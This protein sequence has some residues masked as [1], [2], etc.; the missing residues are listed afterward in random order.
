MRAWLADCHH[1]QGVCAGPEVL[2]SHASSVSGQVRGADSGPGVRKC[3]TS[4]EGDTL[5]HGL[6]V[7]GHRA[8]ARG[9]AG[10]T[11]RRRCRCRQEAERAAPGDT[12]SRRAE[13]RARRVARG[14]RLGKDSGEDSRNQKPEDRALGQVRHGRLRMCPRCARNG[15][16]TGGHRADRDSGNTEHAPTARHRS[17]RARTRN[18]LRGGRHRSCGMKPFCIMKGEWRSPGQKAGEGSPST[19]GVPLAIFAEGSSG[20][21]CDRRPPMAHGQAG[22]DKC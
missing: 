11:R 9:G 1:C 19:A 13:I 14:S 18:E 16:R 4:E 6:R 10:P 3:S 17:R 21:S 8:Q 2:L 5:R 15:V 22:P 7:M 20:A 12:D